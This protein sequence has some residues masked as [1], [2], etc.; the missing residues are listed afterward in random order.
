MQLEERRVHHD[1]VVRRAVEDMR[2]TEGIPLEDIRLAGR[3]VAKRAVEPMD[4]PVVVRALQV[5]LQVAVVPGEDTILDNPEEGSR[6]HLVGRLAG[7]I[8]DILHIRT[9][10]G[11]VVVLQVEDMNPLCVSVQAE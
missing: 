1:Q 4:W 11:R 8:L 7:S 6:I 3:L 2:R 9:E 10:L 5:L